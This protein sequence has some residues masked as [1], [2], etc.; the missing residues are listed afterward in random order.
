MIDTYGDFYPYRNGVF[1]GLDIESEVLSGVKI[2]AWP[3]GG[4]DEGEDDK[5]P[6]NCRIELCV[7]YDD[8]P[9][10]VDLLEL[11]R[12][13]VSADVSGKGA[14]IIAVTKLRD[15]LNTIIEELEKDER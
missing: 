12:A 9:S 6:E 10:S 3:H 15:G 13:G 7:F 1:G 11:L 5:A 14:G 4:F 8:A 2:V